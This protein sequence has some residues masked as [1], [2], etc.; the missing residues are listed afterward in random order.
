MRHVLPEEM[1]FHLE[2]QR[3]NSRA[4]ENLPHSHWDDIRQL[5]QLNVQVEIMHAG[6]GVAV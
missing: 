2:L 1:R 4:H 6:E 3:L 5:I